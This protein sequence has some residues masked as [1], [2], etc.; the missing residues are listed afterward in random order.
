MGLGDVGVMEMRDLLLFFSMLLHVG[1]SV[2]NWFEKRNDKTL[3]SIDALRKRQEQNERELMI[4]Q[5]IFKDAPKH[6]HLGQVYEA[7][8][9]QGEVTNK[10]IGELA[11]TVNQLVGENRSQ[12]DQ[13][14]LL[15]N[16]IVEKG[17]Q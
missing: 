11:K 7:I 9:A 10:A 17:M 16:R 14:R 13:L 15:F 3:E 4:L 12:T 2:W 1:M 8:K 5:E 6:D